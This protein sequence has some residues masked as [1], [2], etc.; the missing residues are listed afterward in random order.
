MTEEVQKKTP[1]VFYLFTL[2]AMG[3][4]A[5]SYCSPIW[6]VTLKAPNYPPEVYPEGVRILFHVDEIKNGC[7]P[8]QEE[9]SGYGADD[10]EADVLDCTEEMDIIN[11][12]IGMEPMEVGGQIEMNYVA[13]Y[14]YILA[15]LLLLIFLFYKGKGWWGLAIPGLIIAPVFII[16]YSAWLWWFG[17]NLRDT[18]AFKMKPFMPTVF[19]ESKVAQFST[20]SYPHY[21]FGMLCAASILLLLAI[22][23]RRKALKQIA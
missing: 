14:G 7:P 1:I 19:G 18:A 6:W 16:D 5:A 20:Y 22:L 11:H 17:H 12:Y 21:G 13:P 4:I 9:D 8:I 23:I 3:L 2:I 15:L 10:D